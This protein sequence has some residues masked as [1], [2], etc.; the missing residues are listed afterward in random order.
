MM[1]ERDRIRSLFYKYVDNQLSEAEYEEFFSYIRRAKQDNLLRAEIIGVFRRT[2]EDHAQSGVAWESLLERIGA[3][4]EEPAAASRIRK[5]RFPARAAAA[6]VL[7]LLAA[8]LVYRYLKH[9]HTPQIAASKPA[10]LD[11]LPGGQKATLTLANG[12]VVVLDTTA[13]GRLARQGN[14]NVLKTNAG[15]LTYQAISA[16]AGAPSRVAYN[17]LSTPKGGEYQLTLSDGTK[18][19]L[20]AASSIRYPTVF[21]GKERL[22]TVTGEAYFEVQHDSRM[23]FKVKA[24]NEILE[25]L[26]TR[27]NV[28]AYNDE[29]TVKTTLLEGSIRVDHTV[30]TPGQQAVVDAEG[31]MRVIVE[32]NPDDVISWTRGFFSF[33]NATLREVMRKLSRWYDIEVL[34]ED[35]SDNMQKFSGHIDRSLTLAELLNGLKQTKA[36]FRIDPGRKVWILR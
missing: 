20:N 21:T 2:R 10:P 34:Y 30:L 28:N 32:K 33:Q 18:V 1:Q 29:P 35:G 31:H 7:C 11:I 6:A 13:N 15:I 12:T 17:V 8:G 16:M 19:W 14:A 9:D 5:I 36:H 26:G 4:G 3:T 24:G 25:D 27:F 23:P 22:V